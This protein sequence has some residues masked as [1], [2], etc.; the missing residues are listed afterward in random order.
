SLDLYV[1][2]NTGGESFGM[3]LTEAMAAGA[4]VVASDLDAFRRVLDG[5]AA[6]AL[7]PVGDPEA[8]ADEL[9]RLLADPEQRAALAARA[10]EAVAAYDW[11]VLAERVL[12]V[13]ASAIDANDR[14]V[15]GDDEPLEDRLFPNPGA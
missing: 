14:L 7:F 8:L 4:A 5:G 10:R 1:A 13:Y 3:I 9:S 12:E 15:T 11:P 2:P 6:G